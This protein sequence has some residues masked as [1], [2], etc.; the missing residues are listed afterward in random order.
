MTPKIP[1]TKENLQDYLFEVNDKL[2]RKSIADNFNKCFENIQGNLVLAINGNW[3]DGKSAFL[4]MWKNQL[5]L[6]KKE[7]IYINLWEEDFFKEPFLSIINSFSDKF[8]N[9]KTNLI[10][11]GKKIGKHLLEKKTGINIDTFF[12]DSV[13]E[14]IKKQKYELSKILNKKV[15]ELQNDFPLIVMID[16]L[17]RC[18]P[19]YAIEFLETIKHFFDIDKIVFILGIDMN[20]LGHSL[21][22]VYGYNMNTERYLKKIIDIN[23]N[24]PEPDIEKYLNHMIGKYESKHKKLYQDKIYRSILLKNIK[25]L[26]DIEKFFIRYNLTYTENKK[27]RSGFLTNSENIAFIEN[28]LLLVN[29][30]KPELYSKF[31]KKNISKEDFKPIFD[32]LGL[33]NIS[34]FMVKI[35]YSIIVRTKIKSLS[36]MTVERELKIMGY[37]TADITN[38]N[39]ILD[40]Y[41][42][43]KIFSQ[44]NFLEDI[45]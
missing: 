2:D 34:S 7:V 29:I 16:E 38:N 40:D 39:A 15:S 4:H 45:E 9:I 36:E 3:G 18:N 30:L 5:R 32:F 17:D 13:Y 33:D 21:K 10:D 41:D 19:L 1:K 44:I 43:L 8:E 31:I 35:I 37:N 24:L 23:Y 22:K 12:D 27:P 28:Y 20:E 6:D 26:R 11:I 25:N 14:E 42:I